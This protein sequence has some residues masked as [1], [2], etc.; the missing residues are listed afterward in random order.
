MEKRLYFLF[1]DMVSNSVV[2]ILAGV[3]TASL[4]GIDWPML[5][6]MLVG[7][8]IGMLV[9][10]LGPLVFCPWF[11]ALEVMIPTMLTGML[12]GMALGMLAAMSSLSL[13]TVG[14]IGACIGLGVTVMVWI[15]SAVLHGEHHVEY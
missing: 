12:S 6:G 8:A 9:S 10:L 13:G 3:A 4:V 11:G 7:M 1:G 15:G 5:I 2:G 14:G